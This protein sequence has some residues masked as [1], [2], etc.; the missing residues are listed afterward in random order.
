MKKISN[1]NNNNKKEQRNKHTPKNLT[2]KSKRAQWLEKSIEDGKTVSR[3][4]SI[5]RTVGVI[6]GTKA[7]H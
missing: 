2:R 7:P 1:K 4:G 6:K 5:S 3:T